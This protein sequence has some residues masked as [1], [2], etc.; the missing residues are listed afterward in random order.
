[1]TAHGDGRPDAAP[2]PGRGMVLALWGPLGAAA[3]LLVFFIVSEVAGHTPFVYTPPRNMAEAAALGMAAEVLRSLR[4]GEDPTAVRT[5]GP[6]IISPSITR[7]TTLE[8]AV[9]SRELAL[10]RLLDRE[11]AIRD[12]DR[13]HLACVARAIRAADL[14]EYLA[15]HGAEGCDADATLAAIEARR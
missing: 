2:E 14:A 5:V 6:E 4:T 9:W 1:V 3:L 7:V 13:R 15:P 8:S 11:G 12:D 10:V